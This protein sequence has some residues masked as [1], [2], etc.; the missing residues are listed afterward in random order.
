MDDLNIPQAFRARKWLEISLNEA[1]THTKDR[2]AYKE[3]Q[4]SKIFYLH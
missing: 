3:A 1:E 4:Q 2:S